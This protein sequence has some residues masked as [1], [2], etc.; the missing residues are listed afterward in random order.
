[1]ENHYEYD[2]DDQE[3]VNTYEF[4]I[5]A[6]LEMIGSG[7]KIQKQSQKMK[8]LVAKA[9]ELVGTIVNKTY[10]EKI[11]VAKGL[12]KSQDNLKKNLINT[13]KSLIKADT[14]RDKTTSKR[15]SQKIKTEQAVKAFNV[16]DKNLDE[17]KGMFDT[18]ESLASSVLSKKPKVYSEFA[19]YKT[20]EFRDLNEEM[21]DATS[22][23]EEPQ[24]K[25]VSSILKSADQALKRAR[26]QKSRLDKKKIK[27]NSALQKLNAAV[28]LSI[29]NR[30][31]IHKFFEESKIHYENLKKHIYMV[32]AA[33]KKDLQDKDIIAII[34]RLTLTE[35][36]SEATAAAAS[37]GSYEYEYTSGEAMYNDDLYFEAYKFSMFGGAA[38][39]NRMNKYT[40]KIQKMI[41]G[42][43]KNIGRL[44]NNK[45]RN[46]VLVDTLLLYGDLLVKLDKGRV[47]IESYVEAA[48]HLK[49][50]ADRANEEIHKLLDNW[51]R[52]ADD[53]NNKEQKAQKEEGKKGKDSESKESEG[54]F[55]GSWLY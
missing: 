7:K 9:D 18:M 8:I 22:N 11:K 17:Y 14:V 5:G 27:G 32:I 12:F 2:R 53:E 35:A 21:T 55:F 26:K 30:D 44:D 29:A 24:V 20:F 46:K 40:D 1:M 45:K 15:D 16:M 4:L 41:T 48:G 36:K 47:D 54:G 23:S 13:R 31:E 39:K 42:I 3:L 50:A 34:P 33:I 25:R 28:K 52:Y 10:T 51:K 19:Q 49:D 38:K 6:H 43:A 37:G